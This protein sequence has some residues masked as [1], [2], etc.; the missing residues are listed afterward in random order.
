MWGIFLDTDHHGGQLPSFPGADS[1]LQEWL[2]S[3]KAQV[4]T[5]V[6]WKSHS[7]SFLTRNVR[8][9]MLAAHNCVAENTPACVKV[10]LTIPDTSV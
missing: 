4:P 8:L 10:L 7:C 6:L 5:C 1:C 2:G 3:H 9:M